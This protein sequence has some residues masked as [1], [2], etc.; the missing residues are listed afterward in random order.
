MT[1]EQLHSLNEDETAMLWF[2]V[3]KIYKPAI[4]DIE[5]EPTLF[6][7]IQKHWLTER[8]LSTQTAIKEE[9]LSIYES[10]KS[11]LGYIK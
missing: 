10:F 7:S 3:N 1:L 6:P 2:M 8:V 11:K 5:I 9:H 4:T